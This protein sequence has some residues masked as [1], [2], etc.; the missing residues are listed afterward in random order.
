[1]EISLHNNIHVLV[2]V[3]IIDLAVWTCV[4]VTELL[5]SSNERI[6]Q[7]IANSAVILILIRFPWRGEFN[8]V[9]EITHS[10]VVLC[11]SS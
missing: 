2:I 7:A 8:D 6:I 5:L 11:T 9:V 3:V 10:F 4:T 1:M